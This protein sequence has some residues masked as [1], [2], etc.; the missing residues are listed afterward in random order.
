[1]N[2][3]FCFL[4]LI[5]NK[6]LAK[7]VDS[8]KNNVFKNCRFSDIEIKVRSIH[9]NNWSLIIL[10]TILKKPLLIFLWSFKW[11]SLFW[12]T[13]QRFHLEVDIVWY[14]IWCFETFKLTEII[15]AKSWFWRL[16][17]EILTKEE[18]VVTFN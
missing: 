11:L 8:I 10:N 15:M 1:M 18:K 12:V 17:D 6:H 2:S 9:V 5:N 16:G 4:D 7:C 13:F 3:F 14:R